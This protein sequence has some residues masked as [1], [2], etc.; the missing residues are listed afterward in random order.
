MSHSWNITTFILLGAIMLV[1]AVPLALSDWYNVKGI[2]V[3]ISDPAYF[4]LVEG[5][6]VSSSTY[7]STGRSKHGRLST[8]YHYSI[9]YE[10]TI[11]GGV[12]ESLCKRTK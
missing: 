1:I 12:S 5:R 4:R 3:Y 7:T 8:I 9:E 11:G 10:F 6:I 2:W